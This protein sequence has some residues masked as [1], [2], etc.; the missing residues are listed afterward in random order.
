MQFVA[1]KSHSS[2]DACCGFWGV[3]T[4][5]WIRPCL[6]PWRKFPLRCRQLSCTRP[7]A[8]HFPVCAPRTLSKMIVKL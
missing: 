1:T 5:P 4:L 7:T 6:V 2:P 3:R 8:N